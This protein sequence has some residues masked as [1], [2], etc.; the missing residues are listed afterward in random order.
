MRASLRDDGARVVSDAGTPIAD[1]CRNRARALGGNDL[2]LVG[3]G[4][5]RP[6]PELGGRCA[7]GGAER[8]AEV[9]RV[10]HSPAAEDLQLHRDDL[11][12]A[13]CRRWS[14]RDRTGPSSDW[15]TTLIAT[16]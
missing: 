7:V 15:N 14:T 8:P 10:R 12:A 4:P 3:G 5:G 1:R 2:R 6:D 13:A 11:F 9:R 16:R